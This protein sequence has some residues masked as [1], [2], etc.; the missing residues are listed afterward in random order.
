M[1]DDQAICEKQHFQKNI[2]SFWPWHLFCSVETSFFIFLIE[3][4]FPLTTMI[5]IQD[6]SLFLL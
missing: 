1:P 5:Q 6:G 2:A 3:K 4:R